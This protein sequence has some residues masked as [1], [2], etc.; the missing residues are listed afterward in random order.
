MKNWM[1]AIYALGVA[2]FSVAACTTNETP[3]PDNINGVQDFVSAL[4]STGASTTEGDPITQPFLTCL[5]SA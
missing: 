1:I 5:G 3:I 4:Q 2:L